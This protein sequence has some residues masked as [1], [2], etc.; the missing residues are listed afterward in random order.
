MNSVNF[1]EQ[2]PSMD[3]MFTILRKTFERSWR[4]SLHSDDVNLW[5]EDFTGKVFAIDVEKR[6]ALW[7]LCNFTYYN[8]DEINHL[9]AL[10]FKY[11]LHQLI[12]DEGYQGIDA[13]TSRVNES[14]FTSIGTASESGGLLLYHFRQEAKLSIDRFFFPAAINSTDD[15]IIVCIDD[16]IISG[17]TA[18]RFFHNNLASMKKK[19]IYFLALIISE[20]ALE[21]L[22][23]LGIC[24]IC[25]E[26]LD[27]RNKVFSPQ[28]LCFHKFPGLCAPAKALAETYGKRIEPSKPLG[29]RNGEYA[30]GTYYNI[31]NNTLPIFW[32]E[33]SNWHPILPRKEKYQNVTQYRR[34]YQ[35]FV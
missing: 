1:P 22:K 32:S 34:E 3:A 25:C 7:L 15:D 5:L 35:T 4:I 20:E 16:V 14:I 21:K 8:M 17:G 27:A 33:S 31:P 13:I 28:S 29:Y 2:F 12:T 6:L 9:C 11:F 30:F 23:E 19:K 26:V 18:A 24:V 10:L